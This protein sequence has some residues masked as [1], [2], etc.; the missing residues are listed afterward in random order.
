MGSN[1]TAACI[2]IPHP[3]DDAEAAGL[4]YVSDEEPGL[5]RKKTGG[6]FS[7]VTSQ[8]TKVRD[9]KTLKRIRKLAIPPTWT[10][11]C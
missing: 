2:S 6:G 11:V 9:E 8:G 7:Y 5:R 3:E 10:D 1:C 4:T